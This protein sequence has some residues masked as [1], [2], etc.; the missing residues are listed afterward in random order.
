M[1]SL[2]PRK[3]GCLREAILDI[4]VHWHP[5]HHDIPFILDIYVHWHPCHHD[6]PFILNIKKP[7]K[8]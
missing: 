4:Y 7:D 1:D 3:T 6:I 2:M 5:C 8:S